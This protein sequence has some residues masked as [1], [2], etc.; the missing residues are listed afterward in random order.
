[1]PVLED[2]FTASLDALTSSTADLPRDVAAVRPLSDDE[3]LA[4]ERTLADARRAIDACAS[5]VAGEV[6]HRS[7]HELGYEGLAQRT[8]F[9]TPEALVQ[10]VTGSSARDATTLVQVGAMVHDSPAAELYE[11]WLSSVGAAVRTGTLTVDAARAIRSGLGG[12]TA[13][14]SVGDLQG[15]VGHL[16][17]ETPDLNADAFLRRARELRDELDLAGVATREEAIREQ[18]AIRRLIRPNGQRRFI[19][20]ADLE[21]G[22]YL[23][24]VYNKLTSPRR[25]GVRF[26]ADDDRAWSESIA[27]DPRTLEQY[28]HDSFLQLLRIGVEAD[29]RSAEPGARRTIGARQPAVRVLATRETLERREGRGYLEGVTQPI[30]VATVERLACSDGT[31][32][33]IFDEGQVI[34]LGRDARYFSSAQRTAL[35]ARDGGCLW[36]DCERPPEWCEAHHI[37]HW[38][39]DQGRSD[40][41]DGVLLCR[42][43]HMLLH[44]KNW[45]VVRDATEYF[46]VPP[47]L[48]DPARTPIRLRSKSRALLELS[49]A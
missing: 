12:P 49:R 21:S 24:D 19:I 6:K 44:N 36:P 48:I 42:F 14:V 39:R 17:S 41:A 37:K 22:A 43:H 13:S 9:R 31:V 34:N 8:G 47:K 3:L 29:L 33:V 25:G 40:L 16:L 18:R 46:L 15:A 11:P 45:E 23:D 2:T 27:A 7:R 5:L 30:S 35:A 28:A 26:V 32:P 1:M 4:V 20:D 10:H 38:K